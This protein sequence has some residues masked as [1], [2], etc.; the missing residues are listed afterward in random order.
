[1]ILIFLSKL[2]NQDDLNIDV[3]VDDNGV[4]EVILNNV[5]FDNNSFVLNKESI[6]TFNEF[7]GFLE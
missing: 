1:M 7:S 6:K 5:Q 2:D 4:Q 3:V